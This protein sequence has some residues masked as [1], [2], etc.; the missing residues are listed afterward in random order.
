MNICILS[1]IHRWSLST[2]FTLFKVLMKVHL[3]RN[4]L[5]SNSLRNK[6]IT[7]CLFAFQYSPSSKLCS[8]FV[9]R[10]KSI[11]IKIMLG[12]VFRFLLLY[13]LVI[14]LSFRPYIFFKR[15]ITARV[16]LWSLFFIVKS[17]LTAVRSFLIPGFVSLN[18]RLNFIVRENLW[19]IQ[20]CFFFYFYYEYTRLYFLCMH[21][22]VCVC[23]WVCVYVFVCVFVYLHTSTYIHVYSHLYTHI[24]MV[25]PSL[26]LCF[27]LSPSLSIFSHECI[28]IIYIYI[29]SV[30][31][32]EFNVY[33]NAFDSTGRYILR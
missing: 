30:A 26:S 11:Y 14:H 18:V 17:V 12:L 32:V 8:T 23:E 27:S 3:N 21:I 29:L 28:P 15:L 16:S 13:I 5:T 1:H 25:S 24:F 31:W 6:F 19:P 4:V 9:Q 2:C 7:F 22:C 33:E 10:E 20:M